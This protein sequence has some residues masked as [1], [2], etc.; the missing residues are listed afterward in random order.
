MSSDKRNSKIYQQQNAKIDKVFNVVMT[1]MMSLF[2]VMTA[3]M[4]M[5]VMGIIDWLEKI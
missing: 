1:I 2:M 5:R 3:I 4:A